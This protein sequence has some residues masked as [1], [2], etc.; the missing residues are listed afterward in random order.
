MLYQRTNGPENAHLISGPTV[1]TTCRRNLVLTDSLAFAIDFGI[2]R[3][4]SAFFS[5]VYRRQAIIAT[6]VKI[7]ALGNTLILLMID[8]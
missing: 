5:E 8:Y 7:P 3:S 6:G 4:T 1:S 2:F